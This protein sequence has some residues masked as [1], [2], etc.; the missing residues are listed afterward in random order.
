MPPSRKPEYYMANQGFGFEL[1]GEP[2]SVAKGDGLDPSD[3]Y[4][5]KVLKGRENFFDPADISD[6]IKFGPKR[7]VEPPLERATAAPGEKR[8]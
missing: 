7:K 3:P 5:K 2:I 6:F 8:D 1:D 4:A